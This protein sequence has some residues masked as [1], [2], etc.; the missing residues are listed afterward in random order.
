MCTEVA[1]VPH[2]ASLCWG[3]AGLGYHRGDALP[4]GH[5]LEGVGSQGVT[6][7]QDE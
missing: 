2:M 4:E 1:L 5:F 3:P 6:R 7:E